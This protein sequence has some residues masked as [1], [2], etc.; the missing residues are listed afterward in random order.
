LLAG[1]HQYIANSSGSIAPLIHLLILALYISFAYLHG[2]IPH[3][4][5]FHFFLSFHLRIEPPE[6]SLEATKH[7]FFSCFSS[8]YVTVIF[9]FLVHDYFC[10][11]SLGLLYIL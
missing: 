4:H 5:F 3:L 8:F 10:S 1:Y 9:V 11:V 7:E 6:R 2:L